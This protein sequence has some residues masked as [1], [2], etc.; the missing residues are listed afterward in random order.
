MKTHDLNSWEEYR[1]LIAEV[2]AEYGHWHRRSG[3]SGS[4]VMLFRGQAEARWPLTTTLERYSTEQHSVLQY[5]ERATR[6][7]EELESYTGKEWGLPCWP[8]LREDVR[9]EAH[10]RRVHLP[11]YDYLVYLRHLGFPS[12]L[13]DWTESPYI[14]AFFA[15]ADRRQD[16]RI[17]VYV[18]VE[19]VTGVKGG[20]LK[21]PTITHMGPYVNAHTRHFAQKASYTIATELDEAN[22]E[23]RFCSHSLIFERDHPGQDLLARITMPAGERPK[24]LR[25]LNDYNINHFTVFRSEEALASMLATKVFDLDQ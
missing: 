4:N 22:D 25:E 7:S 2:R 20:W 12:P 1:P 23:H 21:E 19:S 11:C 18:Y 6:C 3:S 5:V 24:A 13:L 15:F 14:A 17:A 9:G 16:E 10:G 8:K